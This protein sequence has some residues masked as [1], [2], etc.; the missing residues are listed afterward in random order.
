M[1]SAVTLI[2]AGLTSHE[3]RDYGLACGQRMQ[4]RENLPP[5]TWLAEAGIVHWYMDLLDDD[6]D[7]DRG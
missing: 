4:R 5:E 1:C 3:F 2:S 6:L 7:A